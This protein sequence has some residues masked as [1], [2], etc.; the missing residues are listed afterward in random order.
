M[1]IKYSVIDLGDNYSKFVVNDDCTIISDS[2]SIDK[3]CNYLDVINNHISNNVMLDES[4]IL[5]L[6]EAQK[7]LNGV[8]ETKKQPMYSVQSKLNVYAKSPDTS[9]NNILNEYI[10]YGDNP[11]A[12]LIPEEICALI[13]R[14]GS[15]Q[16]I[17]KIPSP[18]RSEFK[19]WLSDI[20]NV[21]CE[22]K[23]RAKS[24]C[25]LNARS[26]YIDLEFLET[27][28]GKAKYKIDKLG[29]IRTLFRYAKGGQKLKDVSKHLNID[30]HNLS[31]YLL[32]YNFTGWRDLC[33][34]V[35]QYPD[36]GDAY[37]KLI[38]KNKEVCL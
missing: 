27:S 32:L 21:V 38:E 34:F 19:P 11:L 7:L 22:H 28:F 26:E 1:D 17:D 8:F 6:K 2:D 13:R 35:E 20:F 29:G 36:W 9:L 31:N 16:Q 12:R 14:F 4:K 10:I 37:N 25:F 33:D 3:L 24:I 5:N 15:Q 30:L 18:Y 23:N